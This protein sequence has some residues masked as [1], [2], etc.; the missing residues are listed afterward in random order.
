MTN[1]TKIMFLGFLVCAIHIS[2]MAAQNVAV[3]LIAVGDKTQATSW[4]QAAH[5]ASGANNNYTIAGVDPK[6]GSFYAAMHD[7]RSSSIPL[8][9]GGLWVVWDATMTKVWCYL[10]TD[11]I[12]A[13]RG[14][15]A[16]P[17]S[18]LLLDPA[19]LTTPGSNLEA[20]LP[21]DASALPSQIFNAINNAPWDA[22]MTGNVPQTNWSENK[23]ILSIPPKP[24][25]K[26]GYGPA[27]FKYEILGTNDDKYR[28]PVAFNI[29]GT[30]PITGMP[31]PVYKITAMRKSVLVPF[32][33]AT[34][35]GSGGIGSFISAH[36]NVTEPCGT[37]SEGLSGAATTTGLFGVTGPG[38]VLN[39]FL[40]DPLDSPW[41]QM[42]SKLYVKCT[43]EKSQE[44]GVAPPANNPLMLTNPGVSVRERVL[45][46][47]RAVNAVNATPDSVSYAIWNCTIMSGVGTYV[48]INNLN[49]FNGAWTGVLPDCT[50]TANPKYP[51][52]IKEELITDSP[53]PP[54]ITALIAPVNAIVTTR[55]AWQ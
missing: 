2:A 42:E 34:N 27:P 22:I 28:T 43:A 45:G 13:T 11:S 55:L 50:A 25:S 21:P 3:Q 40:D 18:Q 51:L 48:T 20:G 49:P 39:V 24:P 6:T 44:T 29:T 9:R 14:F 23:K 30:D 7:V 53:T 47:G 26:Y 16:V 12:L 32:V 10:S 5:A 15:F 38:N 1:L 19:L 4:A 33:N 8:E 36:H 37:L 52:L 35:T 17:R 31:I 41:Y 54:S 46:Q